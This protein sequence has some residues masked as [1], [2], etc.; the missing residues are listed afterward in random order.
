MLNYKNYIGAIDF[1]DEALIFHGTVINT[2]DTITFQGKSAKELK[3][4]FIDSVEDYLA[5]CEEKGEAPDKPFSGKFNLRLTPEL[6]KQAYIASTMA[7]LSL[8]KWIKG[9]IYQAVQQRA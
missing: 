2:K 4:A 8:N 7:G 6:H 9:I 1:D 5:F 3:Q